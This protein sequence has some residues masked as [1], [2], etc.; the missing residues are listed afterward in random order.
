MNVYVSI[1]ILG[2]FVHHPNVKIACTATSIP[3]DNTGDFCSDTDLNT[4]SPGVPGCL[5]NDIDVDCANNLLGSNADRNMMSYKYNCSKTYGSE[6]MTFSPQQ[7]ARMKCYIDQFLKSFTGTWNDYDQGI[8]SPGVVHDQNVPYDIEGYYEYEPYLAYDITAQTFFACTC[9]SFEN[10]QEIA[11]NCAIE[12]FGDGICDCECG[13][14]KDCTFGEC[15]FTSIEDDYSTFTY[16]VPDDEETFDTFVSSTQ[17]Q[18]SFSTASSSSFSESTSSAS[19]AA[20]YLLMIF[21]VL[22]ILQ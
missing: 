3:S 14:D 2:K 17:S 19:F 11:W 12:K 6:A 7:A 13:D 22:V 21:V 18:T 1:I 16:T 8:E 10:C 5:P 15:S 9:C 20:P 4:N